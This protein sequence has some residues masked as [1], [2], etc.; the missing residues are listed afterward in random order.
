MSILYIY[1]NTENIKITRVTLVSGK[2]CMGISINLEFGD[3]DFEHGFNRSQFI[4]TIA[5]LDLQS[6]QIVAQLSPSPEIP[7]LYQDWK[8]QYH[9]LIRQQRGFNNDRPT[10]I[11][12]KS[13]QKQ[14]KALRRQLHEWLKPLSLELEPILQQYRA[15]EIHLVIHTQKVT[16]PITKDTLHRLPWQEWDLSSHLSEGNNSINYTGEASLCFNF[17]K[18]NT[19]INSN[20]NKIRRVKIISIFGSSEGINTNQDRYLISN[21]KRR[22]AELTY[23]TEPSRADFIQLWEQ[24]CDI[25]FFAGHSETQSDTQT[26]VI[27]INPRDKLSLAEI[28]KTLR[29]A[30]AKGLKLAIFNSCDGLGLAKELADLNLPYIIV[31]REVVPDVIAQKFIEHFLSSFAEGKSLFASVKEARDKL[32]E[33]AERESLEKQLSGITWLPIICQTTN[34]PPPSWSDLGG[35]TGTLPDNPYRGLAAFREEDA[36]FYFGR[37]KFIAVF[38]RGCL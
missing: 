28:K 5:T 30:I 10:H 19:V 29:A 9:N 25:L 4:V 8:H 24:D 3:G 17:N 23:L 36:P 20:N 13:C 2:S 1:V 15:D 7:R 22:G 31:W 18:A 37:E 21:L 35:L 6:T 38:G 26:G 11:S 12:S 34:E 14:A 16:S 27:N 33:L 32:Y